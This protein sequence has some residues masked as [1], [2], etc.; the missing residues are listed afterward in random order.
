MKL[1][2]KNSLLPT[3]PGPLKI[4]KKLDYSQKLIDYF[5]YKLE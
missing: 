5:K 3:F 4:D 2:T 1:K